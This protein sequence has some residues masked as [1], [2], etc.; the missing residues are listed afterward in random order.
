MIWFAVPASVTVTALLAGVKPK[1]DE[2]A[3]LCQMPPEPEYR[4]PAVM[5]LLVVVPK[6]VVMLGVVPPLDAS[7]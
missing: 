6:L 7:G 5:P 3:A 1:R 2:L 4:K